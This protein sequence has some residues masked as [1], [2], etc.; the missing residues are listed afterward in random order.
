MTESGHH[1]VIISKRTG[2]LQFNRSVWDLV[3]W[4]L[5][6]RLFL[7]D[8]LLSILTVTAFV[9]W[10]RCENLQRF[11]LHVVNT[12]FTLFTSNSFGW[13][14]NAN[15]DSAIVAIWIIVLRLVARIG[16]DLIYPSIASDDVITTNNHYVIAIIIVG[17]DCEIVCL[18]MSLMFYGRWWRLT[19]VEYEVLLLVWYHVFIIYWFSFTWTR[20]IDFRFV[21]LHHVTTKVWVV[22]CL[23]TTTFRHFIGQV[24]WDVEK[25]LDFYRRSLKWFNEIKFPIVFIA[26]SSVF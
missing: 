13:S 18:R 8:L 2:C 11:I 21:V 12:W 16:T 7:G 25:L 5:G 6:C 26:E 3:K 9:Q 14:R 23:T 24:F 1:V 20:H 10:F 22:L 19:L 15:T 17:P 4:V